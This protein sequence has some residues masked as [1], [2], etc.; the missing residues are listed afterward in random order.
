MMSHEQG[1]YSS[2]ATALH[3]LNI[4]S[5]SLIAQEC[6]NLIDSLIKFM[7]LDSDDVTEQKDHNPYSGQGS[8]SLKQTDCLSSL[9]AKIYC[10]VISK[11]ITQINNP[12][13]TK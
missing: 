2:I 8:E 7:A 1:I 13:S 11:I 4:Q 3:E 9:K 6:A 12:Y 10:L 5:T